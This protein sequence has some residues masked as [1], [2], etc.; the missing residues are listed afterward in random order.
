MAQLLIIE[1]GTV[2]NV[3]EATLGFVPPEYADAPVAPEGVGV[4]WTVNG[5]TYDPP[6]GPTLEEIE[7]EV[8]A[9]ADQITAG[10]DRDVAMAL[11]TVDLV[12]AAVN[13]NLAGLSKAQVRQAYRDRIVDNMRARRGILA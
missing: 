3:I 2:V 9:L 6:S 1:N 7:A 11:A 12:M 8:Q 4:G 13:G 5:E 10:N